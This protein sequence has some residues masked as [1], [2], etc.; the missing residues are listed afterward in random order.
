MAFKGK[1]TPLFSNSDISFLKC[2]LKLSKDAGYF[3][4]LAI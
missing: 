2:I 1:K 4:Y 3:I